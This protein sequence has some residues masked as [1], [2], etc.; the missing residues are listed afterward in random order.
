MIF[1]VELTDAVIDQIS[2]DANAECMDRVSNEVTGCLFPSLPIVSESSHHPGCHSSI[3]SRSN[4]TSSDHCMARARALHHSIL[5]QY[6][7]LMRYVRLAN[8]T[9]NLESTQ[10][11][12]FCRA[13]Q[14][15]LS[16]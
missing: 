13:A 10:R 16:C 6:G 1:P 15:G 5:I 14:A 11:D 4:S 9:N 3:S 12:N 8:G 7:G 2:W